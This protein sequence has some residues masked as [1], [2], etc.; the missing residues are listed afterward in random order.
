M[1]KNPLTKKGWDEMMNNDDVSVTSSE[2]LKI[3]RLSVVGNSAHVCYTSHSKHQGC[4]GTE[5]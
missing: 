1:V 4:T 2:L 3:N 5:L